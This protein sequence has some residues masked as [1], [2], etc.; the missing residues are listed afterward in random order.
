MS[1][2]GQKYLVAF[3]SLALAGALFAAGRVDAQRQAV[4]RKHAEGLLDEAV[5]PQIARGKLVFAKYS[6]NACHGAGGSGG[7]LNINAES[8]GR[9][10]GLQHVFESYTAA[11]LAEKIRTGVGVVGKADPT[12]P[13]PPVRMPAFRDLIAG[14]EMNDLVNYVMSMR[15]AVADSG[16]AAW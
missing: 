5:H 12:G 10:N 13:E 6:C 9:I 15:P 7:I 8:G 1:V 2:T 3:L 4:A 11:E 16:T 14:Q